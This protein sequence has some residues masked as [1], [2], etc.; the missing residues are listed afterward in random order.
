[1]LKRF[2]GCLT[3]FAFGLLAVGSSLHSPCVFADASD[4]AARWVATGDLNVAR[5][6]HTATLLSNG[7]VLVV[8]GIA[9][10]GDPWNVIDSA[11]LYDPGTGAWSVTGRLHAARVGHTAT[12]LPDGRVLVVGGVRDL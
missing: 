5:T 11:E 8:G 4:S 1:M 10:Y 7:K 9:N 6:G 3:S 12:L 2:S